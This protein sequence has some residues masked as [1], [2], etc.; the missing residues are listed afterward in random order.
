MHR[1]A[2]GAVD[3]SGI[4]ESLTRWL[5]LRAYG[6]VTRSLFRATTP[7][8][9]MR[10]RFERFGRTSRASML[11]R[12]PRVVFGGFIEEWACTSAPEGDGS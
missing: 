8:A 3:R 10:R 12:H 11:H 7:P 6:A 5:S 2:R 4:A 1:S 9:T